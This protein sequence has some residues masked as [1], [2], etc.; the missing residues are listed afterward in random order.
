MNMKNIILIFFLITIIIYSSCKKDTGPTL[1][2]ALINHAT[3]F[4][5]YR[6]LYLGNYVGTY[7]ATTQT[8]IYYP[9]TAEPID[10]SYSQNV[11]G[12][13]TKST[14]SDSALTFN[15]Q[16]AQ[17]FKIAGDG[18][19]VYNTPYKYI[20]SYTLQFKNDSVYLDTKWWRGDSQHYYP[21][22]SRFR[23]KKQ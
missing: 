6:D 16:S 1:T 10:S 13:I 8:I 19:F 4:V 17:D 20:V 23:G 18:K 12:E 22:I 11:I 21:Y 5:E 3:P 2:A 14:S 7:V 9:Y 15:L